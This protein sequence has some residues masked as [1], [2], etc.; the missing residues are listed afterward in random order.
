MKSNAHNHKPN[1]SCSRRSLVSDIVTGPEA[2]SL[3]ENIRETEAAM[4]ELERVSAFVPHLLANTGVIVDRDGGWSEVVDYLAH[5]AEGDRALDDLRECLSKV[6]ADMSWADGDAL[7]SR[8]TG[9]AY[10][11]AFEKAR[12][13]Y[14]LG[15]AVGQRLGANAFISRPMLQR[16]SVDDG[17]A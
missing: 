2:G 13:A 5:T 12:M 17:G 8:I 10:A 6:I 3:Q 11:Y 4:A 1:S 7:R 9:T 16:S 14:L 15:I